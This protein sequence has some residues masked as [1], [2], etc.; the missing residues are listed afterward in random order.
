MPTSSTPVL[1]HNPRCSKSRGALELLR[2]RGVEPTIVEYLKTPPSVDEVKSLIEKLGGDP[3]AILRTKE[4]VYGML[5]LDSDSDSDEV[6]MA[7][8]AHPVL[9]ERPLLVVGDRARIGRPV[10]ELLPL[11]EGW[12]SS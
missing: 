6:A 8:A 11:L 12:R 5:G 2:A 3:S 1:Y 7:I 10:E 4:D 9:L